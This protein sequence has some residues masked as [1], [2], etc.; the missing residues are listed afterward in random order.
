MLTVFVAEWYKELTALDE[1]TEMNSAYW[2]EMM[3]VR[4]AVSKP[5]EQLRN[6]KVIKGSLT[7]E[8]TLYCDDALFAKLDKLAEE[9]RFVLITSEATVK[10]LAEKPDNAVE[11][12][13]AGLWIVSGATDKPK[14][15]RCWHHREDVGSNE[16]HP[17]LCQRCVDNV[18]G[19]GEVRS[20]A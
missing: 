10:P 3:E 9:L 11:S 18:A 5:L 6:D 1:S 12:E 19:S 20:Y 4:S 16:E 14:C 2:A 13:L 8:V 17:E 15:S 7:A